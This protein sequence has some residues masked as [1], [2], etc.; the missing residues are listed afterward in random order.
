MR[1]LYLI[2]NRVVSYLVLAYLIYYCYC[3]D[4]LVP[5][6]HMWRISLGKISCCSCSHNGSQTGEFEISSDQE[7]QEHVF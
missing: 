5:L 4:K 2:L 3:V 7:H 1:M 6:N